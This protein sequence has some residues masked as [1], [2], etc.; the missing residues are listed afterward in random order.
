LCRS[1]PERA[2]VGGC[3][4]EQTGAC[5]LVL[6][7]LSERPKSGGRRLLLLLLTEHVTTG[8]C[9]LSLSLLAER[10]EGTGA[11]GS[12]G[13][14]RLRKCTKSPGA[15][16]GSRC[17]LAEGARRCRSPKAAAK[18]T[19]TTSARHFPVLLVILIANF[20]GEELVPE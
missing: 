6:R 4:A 20:L 11:S 16:A 15:G 13:R 19:S 8:S 9:R 1:L 10:A 2:G 5:G 12:G 7:W 17:S 3:L 18:S 14:V